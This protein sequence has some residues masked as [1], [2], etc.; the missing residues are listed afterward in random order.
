MESTEKEKGYRGWM[1]DEKWKWRGNRKDMRWTLL[2]LLFTRYT[3]IFLDI[4]FFKNSV[5]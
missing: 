1:G 3:Q 2:R 5:F 4:M